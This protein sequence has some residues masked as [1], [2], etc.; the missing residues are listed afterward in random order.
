MPSAFSK[1]QADQ[2]LIK[3]D[4]LLVALTAVESDRFGKIVIKLV[5]AARKLFVE[6]Q[7]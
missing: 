7:E 2:V 4:E 6:S 5:R 3:F 1:A